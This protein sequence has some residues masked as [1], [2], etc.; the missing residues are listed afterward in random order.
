MFSQLTQFDFHQQLAETPGVSIV[1]FSSPDCGSCR[2]LKQVLTQLR[3]QQND[4]HFFEVNAQQDAGLVRE[5]ELFHLPA[6]FLYS[7]GEFHCEIQAESRLIAIAN[8]VQH[9]LARPAQ[10]EP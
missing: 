4:W 6:L 7:D 1:F 3:Q 9:A 10:E 5:F 2:H 8:A